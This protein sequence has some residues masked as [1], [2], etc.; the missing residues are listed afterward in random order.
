MK[1]T[2]NAP[3][4]LPFTSASVCFM[5]VLCNCFVFPL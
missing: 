4:F 1:G 2:L 5:H 3:L